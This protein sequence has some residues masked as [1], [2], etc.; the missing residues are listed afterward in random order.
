MAKAILISDP[1]S[2]DSLSIHNSFSRFVTVHGTHEA[3]V[4]NNVGY[5][6][7]GHGYFLEDGYE[8]EN[9]FLGNLG[10]LVKPGIILPSERAYQL[11]GNTG[12]AYPPG[13]AVDNLACKT[14]SELNG[15]SVFWISNVKNFFHDNAAV[16]GTNGYWTFTHTAS[17][18]YQWLATEFKIVPMYLLGKSLQNRV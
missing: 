5:N 13:V 16:G 17:D 12:D 1:S 2:V 7:I 11:C 3:V 15:L 10:V 4:S 18:S 6:C 8:T 14:A 9:H